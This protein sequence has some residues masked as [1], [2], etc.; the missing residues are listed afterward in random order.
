L[1]PGLNGDRTVSRGAIKIRNFRKKDLMRGLGVSGREIG[2][3]LVRN[4]EN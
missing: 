2:N 3:C 1:Y 4:E